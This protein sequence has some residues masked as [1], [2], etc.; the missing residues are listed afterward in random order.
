MEPHEELFTSF[1]EETRGACKLQE[2]PVRE[3]DYPYP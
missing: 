3:L 2:E 1:S